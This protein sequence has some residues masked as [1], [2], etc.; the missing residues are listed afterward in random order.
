MLSAEVEGQV[1]TYNDIDDP[2]FIEIYPIIKAAHDH[3]VL[4][5]GAALGSLQSHRVYRQKQHSRRHRRVRRLERR[6]DAA[7]R[8][9]PFDH[10]GDTSRKIYLYDTF[11]GM[12]RPDDVDKRW[13]GVDSLPTWQQFQD[14][15][16][17][18]GY[19]GTVE[20]V[21]NVMRG[22]EYPAGQA[23]LRRGY[24]RGHNTSADVQP[25]GAASTGH[26]LP[27]V[28]LPRAGAS[29]PHAGQRRHSHHRRLRPVSRALARRRT[30]TSPRTS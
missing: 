20:M 6:F 17:Q 16:K 11:A 10:F 26:R 7:C 4:R 8:A 15:G 14:A 19:G 30:N 9:W 1:V 21:R 23:C 13:D 2:F 18:W 29:L 3:V 22:S 24:G 27:Q 12:P 25:V 28:H 5:P